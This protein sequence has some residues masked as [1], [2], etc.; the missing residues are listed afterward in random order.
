MSG[1]APTFVAPEEQEGIIGKEH[2]QRALRGR[3]K[4]RGHRG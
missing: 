3:S 4:S 2:G 1:S